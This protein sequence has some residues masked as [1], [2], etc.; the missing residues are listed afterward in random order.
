MISVRPFFNT[1]YQNRAT[2]A[3]YATKITKI[4]VI[5]DSLTFQKRGKKRTFS[6]VKGLKSDHAHRFFHKCDH[7]TRA[8]FFKQFTQ[9]S[10][11]LCDLCNLFC[12]LSGIFPK[13]L[14]IDFSTCATS[15]D[16]STFCLNILNFYL[17]NQFKKIGRKVAQVA[18]ITQFSR[19]SSKKV[20]RNPE[21]WL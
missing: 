16:L 12:K 19:E 5:L 2:R 9:N 14:R 17:K 3:T 15:C 11:D 6:D 20:A 10:C 1:S 7:A 8:T 18:R 4:Q 13:N 21:L